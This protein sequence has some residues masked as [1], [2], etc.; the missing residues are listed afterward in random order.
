MYISP[1][2]LTIFG[3]IYYGPPYYYIRLAAVRCDQ[4][5]QSHT[6]TR[7]RGSHRGEANY[8]LQWIVWVITP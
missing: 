8:D 2:L 4:V 1:C 5:R 7:I 3:S 6:H